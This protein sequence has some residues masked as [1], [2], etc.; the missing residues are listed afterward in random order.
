[1][2]RLGLCLSAAA[3][4]LMAEAL[5][6]TSAD[7]Q[8]RRGAAV[9][10]RGGAVA[11]GPRGTAVRGPHGGG[12]YRGGGYRGGSYRGYSI[13]GSPTARAAVQLRTDR[14]VS[15][16]ADPAEATA[17]APTATAPMAIAAPAI[18]TTAIATTGIMTTATAAATHRAVLRMARAVAPLL[19]ALAVWRPADPA[20]ATPIAATAIAVG[21]ALIE[22]RS[23]AG[24]SIA[25]RGARWPIGQCLAPFPLDK[26]DADGDLANDAE[27]R[28]PFRA[29]A[30]S[31]RPGFRNSVRPDHGADHH[32]DLQR[33]QLRAA[34][35]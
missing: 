9:G 26:L 10:P 25:A 21:I 27:D 2:L 7:A 12:A 16:P 14:A 28:E 24:S 6:S 1:M 18:T 8:Y 5:F 17:T 13:A 15:R 35:T 20:E 31:D 32:L 3:M 19:T 34:P 30:R 22:A 29:P 33:G 4:I 11:H 23:L